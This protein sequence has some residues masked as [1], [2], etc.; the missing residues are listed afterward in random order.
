MKSKPSTWRWWAYW[1]FG[2]GLLILVALAFVLAGTTSAQ[3]EVRESPLLLVDE[4]EPLFSQARRIYVACYDRSGD[5]LATVAVRTDR[6]GRLI[7]RLPP[8][9]AAVNVIREIASYPS[10]AADRF[11]LGVPRAFTVYAT[12]WGAGPAK[13]VPLDEIRSLRL[14][15]T[16][17]L[18]LYDVVIAL[19]WQP[20]LGRGQEPAITE[21]VDGVAAA[22]RYLTEVTDGQTGFGRVVI[23]RDGLAWNSADIRVKMANDQRPSAFIGGIVNQTTPYDNLDQYDETAQDGRFVAWGGA[24]QF[25]PGQ[26]FLGRYWTGQNA[27]DPSEGAWTE[28]AAFRTIVHEW[29]HYAFF[30]GDQYHQAPGLEVYCPCEAKPDRNNPADLRTQP[31]ARQ[32]QTSVPSLM[33]YHYTTD[34]FW[35]PDATGD[36]THYPQCY[37]TSQSRLH[38]VADWE[39]LGNLGAILGAGGGLSALSLTPDAVDPVAYDVVEAFRTVSVFG[40]P[41]ADPSEPVVRLAVRDPELTHV[42]LYVEHP[43]EARTPLRAGYEG[44]THPVPSSFKPEGEL[45]GVPLSA[46]NVVEATLVGIRPNDTVYIYADDYA[47]GRR[48]AF[49]VDGADINAI[50]QSGLIIGS[51]E[52]PWNEPAPTTMTLGLTCESAES[53]RS[54]IEATFLPATQPDAVEVC[55]PDR[56]IGCLA[57]DIVPVG[58]GQVQLRQPDGLEW[59]VYGVVRATVDEAV[60]LHAWYQFQGGVGPAHIIGDAPMVDGQVTADATRPIEGAGNQ[61]LLSA[62]ALPPSLDGFEAS[63]LVTPPLT[64]STMVDPDGDSCVASTSANAELETPIVYT[65]FYDF[66]RTVAQEKLRLLYYDNERGWVPASATSSRQPNI[67]VLFNNAEAFGID[68]FRYDFDAYFSR[69]TA[70][71]QDPAQLSADTGAEKAAARTNLTWVTSTPQT[72][73]GLYIIVAQE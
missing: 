9:C 72:V 1:L 6:R 47:T 27:H 31:C 60:R 12:S 19:E 73:G 26:V 3:T 62:A 10:G 63:R 16:P 22:S 21:L 20:A 17:P 30:L 58:N 18:V 35:D 36:L 50:A 11:R 14:Y 59:P 70:A 32:P 33:A 13:P 68:R 42:Q 66:G 49:V 41:L 45:N 2:G 39:T 48:D 64:F 67:D 24:S 5:Y 71:T 38:G 57:A 61:F 23:T 7:T 54:I 44:S 25:Q 53:P 46:A 51:D 8:R 4:E 28:T 56:A 34:T 37:T 52:L 29:A 55:S 15:R 65:V 43:P 69:Q 40:A